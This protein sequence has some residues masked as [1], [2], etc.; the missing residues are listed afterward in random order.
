MAQKPVIGYFEGTDPVWLTTLIANGCDTLPVSNGYDGHG[1]NIM[2]FNARDKVD[3]VI[4]FPH[5]VIAPDDNPLTTSDIL[6]P[7]LTYGIPVLLAAPAPLHDSV[8]KLLKEV[9]S[10]IQLVDPDKIVAEV[11][12][13]IKQ[14]A[15][16]EGARGA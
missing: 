1:K 15:A 4:G 12:H 3:L 13:R 10:G 8:R 6:H 7:C 5:K 14:P 11:L 16:A 9:A 2:L